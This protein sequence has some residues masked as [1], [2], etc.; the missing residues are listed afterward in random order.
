[1][2]RSSRSVLRDAPQ[3]ARSGSTLS[4]TSEVTASFFL[5]EPRR[6]LPAFARFDGD[7]AFSIP[8]GLVLNFG[9]GGCPFR[10]A[11]SSFRS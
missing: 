8:D 5:T 9:R 6:S 3:A 4:I 2:H 10:R 11:I 1:M 7:V